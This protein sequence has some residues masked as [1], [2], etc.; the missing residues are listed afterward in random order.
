M[1]ITDGYYALVMGGRCD[2]LVRTLVPKR[3]VT[4]HES[5]ACR[6]VG[7]QTE[8]VF[9]PE[10]LVEREVILFVCGRVEDALDHGRCGGGGHYGSD[11]S[12][13]M[14]VLVASRGDVERAMRTWNCERRWPSSERARKMIVC[15]DGRA[16][17][18]LT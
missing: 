7:I 6:P 8:A 5:F 11:A 9:L 17:S 15:S 2:V 14:L 12:G 16:E 1:E 4:L 13:G 3:A 10:K 18:C